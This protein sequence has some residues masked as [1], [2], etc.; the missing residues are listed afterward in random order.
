MSKKSNYIILILGL[1]ILFMS[2]KKLD[3][4]RLPSETIIGQLTDIVTGKPLQT[5]P[6][7]CRL[8]MEELSWSDNP[9]P[10]FLNIKPDGTF[11]N[12]KVFAGKYK[13]TPVDGPFVPTDSK[14]IDIK[15]TATVDFQVE[16]FLNISLTNVEQNGNSAFVSFT[17]SSHSDL[18][19]ITDAQI[20]VSNTNFVSDGSNISQYKKSFDLHGTSNI[21]IF[22]TTYSETITGLQSG[23]TYYIRVGARCDDP[24][25]K[26]YN[27]S[28][29]K[30]VTIP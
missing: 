21:D 8:K 30:E 3:N 15:G 6:G 10:F 14:E 11:K 7:D 13:I 16:P 2:C 28:E 5:Q 29:V 27:Y 23:R 22:A 25:T 18:Y 26:R 4:Y 20:F 19:K 12:T 24:F 9:V 17:I 1:S